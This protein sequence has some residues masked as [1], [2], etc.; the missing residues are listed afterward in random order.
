MESRSFL[1]TSSDNDL[2]GFRDMFI[3]VRNAARY[4]STQG[5]PHL[6]KPAAAAPALPA[7]PS[8]SGGDAPLAAL[9]ALA[10][11][12]PSLPLAQASALLR[13]QRLLLH[14]APPPQLEAFLC[15]ENC[16]R[17]VMY[18]VHPTLPLPLPPR[19]TQ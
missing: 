14:V 15:K 12:L 3:S 13:S 19:L 8:C 6:A 10:V 11:A 4:C 7:P 18:K 2:E 16:G 9:E 1:S 17:R 5:A